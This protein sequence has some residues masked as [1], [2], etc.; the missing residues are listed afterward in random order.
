LEGLVSNPLFCD[1]FGIYF[2][3]KFSV[4][5]C[6]HFPVYGASARHVVR[7]RAILYLIYDPV[8]LFPLNRT[9]C[10]HGFLVGKEVLNADPHGIYVTRLA[11]E[12]RTILL[13]SSG[14]NAD[15]GYLLIETAEIGTTLFAFHGPCH[16]LSPIQ[17]S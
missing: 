3:K 8:A 12:E 1:E 10:E 7:V 16:G 2:G 5:K 15:G 9:S 17:S 6:F 14:S 4:D 13:V 11:Q